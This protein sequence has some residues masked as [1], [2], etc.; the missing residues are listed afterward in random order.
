MLA[1]GQQ[2]PELGAFILAQLG[3]VPY[4]HSDLRKGETRR[5]ERVFTATAKMTPRM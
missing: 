2:R 5:I 4:I 3:P 1:A